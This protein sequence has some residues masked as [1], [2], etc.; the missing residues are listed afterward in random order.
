MDAYCA[1]LQPHKQLC[2]HTHTHAQWWVGKEIPSVYSLAPAMSVCLT[3]KRAVQ[4][5][6]AKAWGFPH[7]SS[8]SKTLFYEVITLKFPSAPTVEL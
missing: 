5:R 8:L 6:L 3:L 1:P 7:S 2:M 4:Q